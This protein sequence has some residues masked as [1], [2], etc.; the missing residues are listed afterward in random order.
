MPDSQHNVHETIQDYRRRRE[1]IG[2]ISRGAVAVLLLAAGIVLIFV[3]LTSENPPSIA[4][5]FS[6]DTPTP[7]ITPR[8]PT[9]TPSPTLTPPPTETA[10]P[11]GPITYIVEEGDTLW[12]IAAEYEVDLLLLMSV[13]NISDSGA[14]S[15]GDELIIP[16]PGT[17]RPTAT[18]L[19]ESLPPGTE[20]VYIVE[21]GDTL[22]GIA[23]EFNTTVEAIA[24]AS[25]IEPDD[26][27]DRPAAGVPITSSFNAY[28]ISGP[29]ARNTMIPEAS[30]PRL[31]RGPRRLGV[32]LALDGRCDPGGGAENG[33]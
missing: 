8:P 25:E 27:L 10:T 15:A 29:H 18:A 32:G 9:I 23:D 21:P 28:G 16:A 1:R 19:P 13:N 12:S 31:K 11:Q 4:G 2:P 33:V 24:E 14:I 20:I 3:W 6:S 30:E 7:T 26:I 17:E 5:L 22:L